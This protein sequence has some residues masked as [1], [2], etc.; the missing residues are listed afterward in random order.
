MW[1]TWLGADLQAVTFDVDQQRRTIRALIVPWGKIGTH[2]NGR[3][4]RFSRGALAFSAAKYV[5]FNND[6]DQA[7]GLGRAIALE[8]TELGQVATFKVNPGPA[9]DRAL[10]LASSRRKTGFSVEVDIDT[11]DTAPDPENPGVLLV[12]LANL[13]GVGFVENPAFDD[14]RLISVVAS[15]DGGR[16]DTCASCGAQLT[17]GVAHTCPTPQTAPAAPAP[18]AAPA[19]I[20]TPAAPAPVAFSAEQLAWMGANGIAPPA[21]AAPQPVAFSA[22]QVAWMQANGWAP[23][24]AA[25]PPA[26]QVTPPAPAQV[27]DPVPYRFDREGNLQPA[28]RDFGMDMIAASKH[29]DVAAVQAVQEW[30]K[31]QFDVITTDVNELNPT[32][33]LPRYIDQREYQSPVWNS[34]NKGAPPNGVQP[35]SWPK[36]SSASGLVGAHTEGTEPS[37]GTYVT[38]NQT[39]TPTAVSGKAKITRETWDMGGTPGIGNLIWRQMTRGWFE[40]LEAR[41]VA[42]LDAASPTAI[43][44]TAGGG[45]TGQTLAAELRSAFAALHYIRGGFR[46]NTGFAQIDF[47]KALTGALADDKRPLFPAIGPSNADGTVSNRYQ[48][49]NVNGVDFL[50]AWALAA[51]GSV[52]A[53]SYLFDDLAVDGWATAPQQLLMPEIEVANVYIGIWGYGAAAINDIT[54]VRE[55]T[56]DPVA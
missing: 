55:I 32:I 28:A 1:I 36:F 13:T 45:T 25:P 40:A 6:H 51:T 3:R 48:A 42:V 11:A 27:T 12:N 14:S 29:G 53:S 18:A 31:A 52:V 38:T 9:G 49:V 26:R 30:I 10:A 4:W 23:T 17:P 37:S 44:L 24:P 20:P 16:M 33:N 41:A 35:F 21:P 15:Q 56:Y 5:R 50:P 22:E 39:V 2:S 47:Y 7:Q 19:A 43:A 54:G 46:F 34:I 8:D